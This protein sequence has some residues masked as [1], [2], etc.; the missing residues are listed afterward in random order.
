MNELKDDLITL[1]LAFGIIF[2]FLPL[3]LIVLIPLVTLGALTQLI[4]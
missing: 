1:G 3:V 4:K 2:L